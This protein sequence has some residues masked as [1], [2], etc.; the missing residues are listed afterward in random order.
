MIQ[1]FSMNMCVVYNFLSYEEIN[2]NDI[3]SR[4]R[5]FCVGK[6]GRGRGGN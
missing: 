3:M 2:K 1:V 6:V 4:K 5:E